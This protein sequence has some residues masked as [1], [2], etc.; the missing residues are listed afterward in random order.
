[1]N[2][3]YWV[4][5]FQPTDDHRP[6]TYPPGRSILGWWCSGTRGHDDVAILCAMVVAPNEKGAIEVVQ[7]DWPEAEE[8]RFIEQKDTVELGDRFPVKDWMGPRFEQ[9]N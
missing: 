2:N 6:L 8:W 5:W 7:K 4:S 3:F 1:M 9:F